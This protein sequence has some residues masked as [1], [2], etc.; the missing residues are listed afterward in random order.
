[1]LLKEMD[2]MKDTRHSGQAVHT[3]CLKLQECV[4]TLK[5]VMLQLRR[6]IAR[7]PSILGEQTGCLLLKI[8][9]AISDQWHA[10]RSESDALKNELAARTSQ[11]QFLQQRVAE[12]ER[13]LER[14]NAEVDEDCNTPMQHQISS[15]TD[16]MGGRSPAIEYPAFKL[17]ANAD[18][19]I[20]MLPDDQDI[21][22]R[23]KIREHHPEEHNPSHS[24][25]LKTEP[26]SA[27]ESKP[28][29]FSERSISYRKIEHN[30][31]RSRQQRT[32]NFI[33]G[34][35]HGVEVT[36]TVVGYENP[37][38]GYEDGS[39]LH[40]IQEKLGTKATTPDIFLRKP[41]F[42][43]IELTS[44]KKKGFQEKKELLTASSENIESKKPIWLGGSKKSASRIEIK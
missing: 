41:S 4:D 42:S 31:S 24:N 27:E 9:E 25:I 1:M 6:E 37:F 5:D 36:N 23:L 26:Y 21:R 38:G 29:H 44:S 19:S 15:I 40:D 33:S 17:D 13:Q 30:V 22:S 16:D 8:R 35:R 10:H 14:F 11:N 18:D 32:K 7:L 34:F 39:T 12:L 43:R 28:Y 20:M 3:S 2:R